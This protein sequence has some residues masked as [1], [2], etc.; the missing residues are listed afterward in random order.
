MCSVLKSFCETFKNR[1][2]KGCII[3][4]RFVSVLLCL[5]MALSVTTVTALADSSNGFADF[6]QIYSYVPESTFTD[7]NEN[8][9]YG[10]NKQ[11]VVRQAFEHG[12][13]VGNPSKQFLPGDPI[14]IAESI[15]IAARIN[16]IY[17]TGSAEFVQADGPDWYMVYV[18]YAVDHG[19]ISRNQFSNYN[20]NATRIQFAKIFANALP[21]EALNR[22]NNIAEG[23]IPDMPS[24]VQA[25]EVYKLYGAG[26]L[27]GRENTEGS[28]LHAFD[29]LAKINR[30]EV[31]AITVRMVV[32]SQRHT[33]GTGDKPDTGFTDKISDV[34]GK[35]GLTDKLGLLGL[36]GLP[37]DGEIS[38]ESIQD[39][40][41]VLQDLIENGAGDKT[42]ITGQLAGFC[43]DLCEAAAGAAPDNGYLQTAAGLCGQI[44]DLLSG[45]NFDQ[46]TI[47]VLL[48]KCIEA[49]KSAKDGQPGT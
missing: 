30:A 13:M 32:P 11:G 21:N 45:G 48:E 37:M 47:E 43:K 26:I 29:P 14:T 10:A 42:G 34:L 44:A 27:T 38:P 23:F 40:V 31:A 5:I 24:I 17:N 2:R 20:A 3:I 22:I 41:E 19:I 33:F 8:E 35:L 6:K 9:W 39:A 36:L 28:K 7:I 1:N 15:T 25:P 18:D 49:L 12:L 4:K 46:S 16:S